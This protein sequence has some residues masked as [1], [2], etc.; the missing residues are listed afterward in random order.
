MSKNKKKG[1]KKQP[2]PLHSND[3]DTLKVSQLHH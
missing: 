1:G 2:D 3:P